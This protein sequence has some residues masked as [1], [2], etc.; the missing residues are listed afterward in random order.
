MIREYN[1]LEFSKYDSVTQYATLFFDLTHGFN[2]WDPHVC[3]SS[4][5]VENTKATSLGGTVNGLPLII[6]IILMTLAFH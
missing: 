5:K 3:R 4:T 6:T 2:V 1:V